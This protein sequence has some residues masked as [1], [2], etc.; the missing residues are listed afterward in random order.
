MNL[1]TASHS[2]LTRIDQQLGQLYELMQT[3]QKQ[4]SEDAEVEEA[5]VVVPL[6]GPK[7]PDQ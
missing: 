6:D 1:S 5:D 3:I 7:K 2:E 4:N